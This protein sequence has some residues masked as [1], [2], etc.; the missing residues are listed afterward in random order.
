MEPYENG[1]VRFVFPPSAAIPD[2]TPDNLTPSSSRTNLSDLTTSTANT[3]ECHLAELLNE[4]LTLE[5]GRAQIPKFRETLGETQSLLRVHGPYTIYAGTSV[6]SRAPI[7][8]DSSKDVS[9]EEM[10][11]SLAAAQDCFGSAQPKGPARDDL[12]VFEQLWR[13]T[14]S[15][16]ET[17]TRSDDLN[18]ETLGWGMFGMCAGHVGYGSSQEE[19]TF[20]SLKKRLHIALR[21]MPSMDAPIRKHERNL[22]KL[23]GGSTASL[24]NLNREIN[25]TANLL[26]QQ[27]RREEYRKIR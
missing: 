22:A 10:A 17:I 25:I 7:P 3:P 6:F 15:V 5:D 1:R 20:L 23:T 24:A 21:T 2:Y 19:E 8:R 18:H 12:A 9:T 11:R 16:L 4:Q 13:I 14:V 27:F 26:L